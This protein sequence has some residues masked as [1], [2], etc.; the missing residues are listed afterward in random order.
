MRYSKL[1]DTL[2]NLIH[3]KPSQNQLGEILGIRQ[4]AISGRA[5][6]DSEF[7]PEELFKIER[8]YG[9]PIGVLSEKENANTNPNAQNIKNLDND[10]EIITIDKAFCNSINNNVFWL[11]A[12]GDSMSPVIENQDIVLIDTSNTDISNGG[13]FLFEINTKRFIKRLRLRVTG[14]LDIISDNNKYPLETVTNGSELK[15]IGR[16][17]K[18]LSRYL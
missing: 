1:L 3:C 5:Q 9:L 4:T 15:V 10:I 13:I 16:V 14:E 7:T 8:R 2:Q 18:N 6:R 17:I 12:T 11:N